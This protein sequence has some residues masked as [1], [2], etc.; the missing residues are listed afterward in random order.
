MLQSRVCLFLGYYLEDV[1]VMT[2]MT[3]VQKNYFSK[4]LYHLTNCL[5]LPEKSNL[6]ISL[7]ALDSI[8]HILQNK[9]HLELIKTI[10]N[11]M[12][13]LL[14]SLIISTEISQLFDLIQDLLNDYFLFLKNKE[15]VLKSLLICLRD[16]IFAEMAKIKLSNNTTNIY[17]NKSWNIIRSI[18][19]NKYFLVEYI[20]IMEGQLY[21][22]LELLKE[23]NLIDFDEDILLL[24]AEFI[25]KS[26]RISSLERSLLKYFGLYFEKYHFVFGN[27]FATLNYYVHYGGDLFL[28]DRQCLTLV[29]HYY[30]FY[31][32]F[33]FN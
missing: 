9:E 27:L 13:P 5:K 28:N 12:F 22:L 4:Y 10:I 25:K 21:S 14:S 6:A 19:E 33:F 18:S 15:E 1:F 8:N 30:Y 16:R 17:I 11:E 3:Y 7:Q 2:E 26:K 32:L 20:D 29:F 31:L 24:I 23:P